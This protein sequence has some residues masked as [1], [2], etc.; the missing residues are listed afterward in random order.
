MTGL[1]NSKR[2]AFSRKMVDILNF[3]SLNLALGIGYRL[4][5]FDILD[6]FD[7][8]ENIDRIAEESGLNKRYIKEW[9]GI[10]VT[11]RIIELSKDEN[12][13]NLY[14]LPREHGDFLAKRSG[15]SNMGVYTQ[16]IPL[17]TSCAFEP[18]LKGFK[19][20]EGVPFSFYPEFQAF[21]TEL[22]NAKHEQVLVDKFLP[23]INNGSLVEQLKKG[24]RVCDLGC[25]EGAALNLMAKA[26]PKSSFIG[27]DLHEQ[28]VKTAQDSARE[29]GLKNAA[30]MVRDAALL[31]KDPG[32]KGFF[33]FITAFD[34]IH[35][36][37]KPLDALKGIY[38]MLRPDG[39]FSMVDIAS[40][41]DHADNMDHF[42][43]PFLYTV[44]LMHCMPVGLSDQGTGLG[45]MWGREKALELLKQAGFENITISALPDDAF[46]L[47]YLCK[48]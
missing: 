30:F 19:T 45:M 38:H 5:L 3:G 24:I 17:L 21:M 12:K 39:I 40:K 48:K 2:E 28:A 42:M 16:E 29:K 44:S 46:N 20:G 14:F 27:I 26:F 37:T 23:S 31:E 6:N 25:G 9:L 11:G 22:S 47:N 36:Q 4:G 34:S 32:L 33:D 7:S 41:T 13:E 1:I 8:P 18:V 43:G 10:M 15:S 35:D